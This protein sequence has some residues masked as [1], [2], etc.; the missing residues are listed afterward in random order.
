MPTRKGEAT[1]A[2][3]VE[4]AADL[5]ISGN[6][7]NLDD[8]IGLTGTSKGQIFHYFP[9]GKDELRRAAAER[10]LSRVAE[11]DAPAEPLTSWPA[12]ERWIDR[13]VEL[14][15]QQTIHDACEIA[16]LAGRALDNDTFTRNLVARMYERWIDNLCEQLSAMQSAGLVRSDAPVPALASAFVAALQGGAIMDRATGSHQHLTN[17]LHQALALL[18]AYEGSFDT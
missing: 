6:D 2:R 16:A 15:S 11:A 4:A 10:H 1:K 8:V 17:A 7:V 18:H 13:I 9:H 5:L 12:W 14:H 3:I